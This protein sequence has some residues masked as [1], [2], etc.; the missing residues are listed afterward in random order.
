MNKS[1]RNLVPALLLLS[2]LAH[3]GAVMDMVTKDASGVETSRAKVYAQSEM[4]RM[5]EVGDGQDDSSMLFLGD[6]LL[7]L[8]HR[9]KSYIVMDEAMLDDVS[10]KINDAMAE[11]EKQLAGMPPEQRAMVEQMMKGDMQGMMGKQDVPSPAPRVESLGSGEWKSYECER[12]AVFEGDKKTQE[13]CAAD[14]DDID[15]AD[16]VMDAFRS[17]AAYI[18]K[19]SESLPMM[20]DDGLNPGELMDQFNGFPVHTVDYVNGKV[21]GESSLESVTEKKLDPGLFTAPD[22]YRRQDP[23]GGR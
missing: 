11:M 6:K 22:D 12:Y 9:E 5:D 10:A 19:M 17:M 7:Y 18:T 3:A 23:F 13:V 16:E 15:G 20:A 14:L 1:A 2:P 4:V 8:D 21:V